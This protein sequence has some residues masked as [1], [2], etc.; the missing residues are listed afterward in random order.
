MLHYGSS[1]HSGRC[2]ELADFSR[3]TSAENSESSKALKNTPRRINLLNGI[4]QAKRVR[5]HPFLSNLLEQNNSESML[6]TSI[7]RTDLTAKRG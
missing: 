5:I 3:N 4:A 7:A 1:L 2:S 6:V